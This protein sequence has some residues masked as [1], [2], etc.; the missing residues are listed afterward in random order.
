MAQVMDYP[1][2]AVS[3]VSGHSQKVSWGT[4]SSG[5]G[6]KS[7][8]S[9]DRKTI[10]TLQRNALKATRLQEM[11]VVSKLGDS[12]KR[13]LIAYRAQTM[14]D[15][16]WDER[17]VQTQ[18][19]GLIERYTTSS[20]QPFHSRDKLLKDAMQM[21]KE[22]LASSQKRPARR[23]PARHRSPKPQRSALDAVGDSNAWEEPPTSE[24][25]SARSVSPGRRMKSPRKLPAAVQRRFE[26]QE[27]MICRKVR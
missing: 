10:A 26:Q 12:L 11:R 18:V 7:G 8:S 24:D 22:I 5:A 9:V 27:A 23:S 25:A 20:G 17:F 21:S 13:S 4:G 19:D 15:G 3:S 1:S 16:P 6:S 14:A 2:P